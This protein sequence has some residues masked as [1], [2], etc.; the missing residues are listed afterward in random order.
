ME[1][2]ETTDDKTTNNET[3]DNETTNEQKTSDRET[4]SR[5]FNLE[6][7]K[8]GVRPA[9]LLELSHYPSQEKQ[10]EVLRRISLDPGLHQTVESKINGRKNRVFIHK[11]E[12][13]DPKK[14]GE[15]HDLWVARMLGF[16]CMGIPDS[17]K[18]RVVSSYHLNN[19]DFYSE[20]CESENYDAEADHRKLATFQKVA[21]EWNPP[22]NVTMRPP[23]KVTH[24]T[25]EIIPETQWITWIEEYKSRKNTTILDK[26]YF[27]ELEGFGLLYLGDYA[28]K[29]NV[30]LK[31]MLDNHYNWM[32]YTALIM[33]NDP[34]AP[35]YPL[36]IKNATQLEGWM[37]DYFGEA[38]EKQKG[39]ENMFDDIQ[40]QAFFP[41]GNTPKHVAE[42]KRIL[43]NLNTAFKNS[44]KTI[45]PP[46]N[47]ASESF[48]W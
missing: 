25:D 29:K 15:D 31:Y 27:G 35:F 7:T 21:D 3:T 34:M 40:A 5:E 28:D 20:I 24:S 39:P 38:I 9:F 8:K 14:S 11:T 22:D 42:F 45:V 48:F 36:T 44:L 18:S 12:T 33:A 46:L 4:V 13:L 30:N 32:L 47:R 19:F 10:N 2:H 1:P 16:Q 41:F 6:L 43:G 26:N 17:T 23:F 37:T